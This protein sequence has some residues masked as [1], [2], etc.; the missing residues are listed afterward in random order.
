MSDDCEDWEMQD[1]EMQE[2]EIDANLQER[3]TKLL[4]ERR[5]VEESDQALTKTLFADEDEDENEEKGGLLHKEMQQK[6]QQLKNNMKREISPEIKKINLQKRLDNEAKHQEFSRKLK[7]QKA[8][9]IREIEL[10]GESTTDDIE[11]DV[12]DAK[13][14][15]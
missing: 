9:K 6:F 14:N 2:F 8:E 4:Q 11:Y 3:M 5:L 12:Y 7:E 13:Y 1:W 15:N 10:F